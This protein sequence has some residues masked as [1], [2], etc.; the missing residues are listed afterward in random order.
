MKT[1]FQSARIKQNLRYLLGDRITS[2]IHAFRFYRRCI[3]HKKV[4]PEL[5]LIPYLVKEGD[6]V[7]D[8]GANNAGWTNALAKQVGSTGH[9]YAFEADPYYAEVTRKT[10]SLLR[11]KNVTLFP[12]GLSDKKEDV[13][14][15][16]RDQSNSRVSGTGRVLN[17]AT[18]VISEDYTVHVRMERLDD[19]AIR[20]P[21]IYSASLIK[22]D[23]EGFELMV[24]RGSENILSKT[25]PIVIVEF[26]H[27]Y[28]HGYS[29][30]DLLNFFWER[31]YQ[32]YKFEI[33]NKTLYPVSELSDIVNRSSPNL[34]F[35]VQP[36]ELTYSLI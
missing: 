27:A 11:L 19:M 1:L 32:C 16:I 33:D 20:F 30:E 6:T 34:L 29:D 9:V 18:N 21:A 26:G 36:L 23:V 4:E 28:L 15:L 2:W 25:N 17:D 3:Q 22:C 5:T 35:S 13:R 12:F 8:I 10:I 24:M 14:L 7:I 31:N